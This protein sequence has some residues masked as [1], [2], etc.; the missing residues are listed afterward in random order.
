MENARTIAQLLDAAPLS[1]GDYLV[2]NQPGVINQITNQ[3]GDTRKITIAQ[4]RKHFNHVGTGII[5][6]GE[7][8]P[9]ELA[10]KRWLP[11][12]Y[13]IIE[14][15]GEYQELC[16][17]MWV[18]PVLNATAPFWYKC[19]I[20]GTRNVNG[21]YMRVA[22]HRGLFWRVAGQ[23]AVFTA[24]NNTPYDGNSVGEF[25]PD[26]MQRVK[27]STPFPML[28]STF[29]GSGVLNGPFEYS[30]WNDS[31]IAYGNEVGYL[32][33]SFDLAL[34]ARTSYETRSASLSVNAYISY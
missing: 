11:L 33:F 34:A 7:I 17:F 18:G 10:K 23:N 12:K 26:A 25:I 9:F 27:T 16:D 19:D 14:I 21:L 2:I 20:D 32:R 6:F 8:D 24:A 13:Q 29:A 30:S 3:L 4:F 31:K 15:A 28:F 22:D 1:D 5:A